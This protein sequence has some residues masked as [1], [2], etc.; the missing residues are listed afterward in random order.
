MAT[1]EEQRTK[2]LDA[3]GPIFA[4]KGYKSSTIR[5]ICQAAEVNIAAVNYYFG[6]K[7]RLYIETVKRASQRL[8]MQFPTPRWNQD[9]PPEDKLRG[10]IRTML[11]RM[12]GGATTPW[13]QRLMFREVLK[14]TSACRE[15]AEEYFRPHFDLLLR[16]LSELLPED[17]SS[18]KL[19][20]I[21]FSVVGQCL[22][23]RIARPV[24]EMLTPPEE[25]ELLNL[26]RIVE[27]VSEF[28]LAAIGGT[29]QLPR[30]AYKTHETSP[31]S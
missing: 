17:V 24:V 4:E 22:H 10:L 9:T 25:C 20:Q 13:E 15:L 7:E 2:L 30:R 27:H 1:M 14:P 26:D 21:G 31:A 8:T 28:T 23:Y 16:V 19:R 11:T 6:D 29:Y 18:L 3:A 5:E 12:I